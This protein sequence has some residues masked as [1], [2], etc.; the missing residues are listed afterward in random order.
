MYVVI[1]AN[2][3]IGSYMIKNILQYTSDSILAIGRQVEEK[4]IEYARVFGMQCDITDDRDIAKLSQKV[5]LM[6]NVKIIYLAAYHHP[7]DVKKNPKVAWNVNVT[8]LSKVLNSLDNVKCL[9]YVSTEMVY[10]E[11]NKEKL[12]SEKDELK[13]VNL[14]GVQKKVAEAIV[15]GYGYNVVR[16]PFVIGPSLLPGKKHFYD[17][18]VD[19]VRS[20]NVI[21]M[22]EDAYK[23]ALDFDTATKLVIE[24]TK[25]DTEVVPKILNVAGDSILSKYDIG[26]EIAK[27]NGL[28]E[29]LIKS[30]RLSQDNKIFN[31]KRASCT[32][33]DNTL[34]KKTLQ[35]DTIKMKF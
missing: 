29:Q 10:G 18:I 24:L 25:M 30:I 27:A 2:G 21:E 4:K 34:L 12:F 9:Y 3:Y 28:D 22:F 19:T 7:D 23:S 16:F 33:L 32:L 11:G 15:L 31:E 35:L 17:I 8:S 26:V 14:Y 5:A 20:G 6:E 1:G 13:P